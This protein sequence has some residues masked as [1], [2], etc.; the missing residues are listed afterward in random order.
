EKMHLRTP[1][2]FMEDSR[3]AR[4]VWDSALDGNISYPLKTP[5]FLWHEGRTQGITGPSQ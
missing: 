2:P 1:Q 5:L 3:S 4:G